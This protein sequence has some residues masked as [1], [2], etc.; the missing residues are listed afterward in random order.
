MVQWWIHQQA[1]SCQVSYNWPEAACALN[2]HVTLHLVKHDGPPWSWWTLEINLLGLHHWL[3]NKHHHH[4][5]NVWTTK[6]SLR[7]FDF[8]VLLYFHWDYLYI[9]IHIWQ[10]Y[11]QKFQKLTWILHVTVNYDNCV[12][13]P[14]LT[15]HCNSDIRFKVSFRPER[16]LGSMPSIILKR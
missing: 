5:N 11:L 2:S 12:L 3:K 10:H 6:Q 8:P 7:G 14:L 16:P 4:M 15:I 9:I 1:C 13:R